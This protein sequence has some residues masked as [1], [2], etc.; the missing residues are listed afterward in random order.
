MS[1]GRR[2]C[3]S[4]FRAK[5]ATQFAQL[6][7]SIWFSCR[8]IRVTVAVI[9]GLSVLAARA[10]ARHSAIRLE[11]EARLALFWRLGR[12]RLMIEELLWRLMAIVLLLPGPGLVTA[13]LGPSYGLALSASILTLDSF[14]EVLLRQEVTIRALGNSLLF[15]ACGAL[16]LACLSV[17]PAFF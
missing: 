6:R 3:S 13:V 14:N 10:A 17:P 15:W 8:R 1:V 7:R 16:A 11:D 4:A 2:A 12:C 9:A 5:K